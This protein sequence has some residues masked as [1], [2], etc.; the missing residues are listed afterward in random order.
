MATERDL[1]TAI[2]RR[3]AAF[4]PAASPSG[5]RQGIGDD[6]AIW[7][8]TPAT[9]SLVTTDTLVEGVHFDRRWHPPRLLGR[10]AVAV[11]MSDIAAMGGTPR[12]ALLSL[13]LGEAENPA[14]LEMMLD[15]LA[16]AVAA[17]GAVLIGGDT[18]KSPERLLLTV[19]II[20][21]S[22]A[23]RACLRSGGQAG[24]SIWVGGPLGLA[25]GGLELCR[26]DLAA[27]PQWQEAVQAHLDPPAQVELG[28]RLAAAGVVH[29]MMDL[30][31]GLA[32][33]LAHIC[34]ASGVGAE[35]EAE[36][37][38]VPDLLHRAAAVCQADPL[39]WALCGGE[40]YRL[41][42]T[43]DP[44]RDGAIA[45]LGRDLA[46]TTLTRIGRLTA[47]PPG[48]PGVLLRTADGQSR[49]IG[50]GGYDHFRTAP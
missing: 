11:N 50:Y 37:L 47:P 8:P 30:S 48:G 23:S 17:Y 43:A 2:A 3:A 49:E 31:D 4:A 14:W 5:L 19:T 33:D 29:A 21:E 32:T 15:G 16:E 18:V 24:D 28:R 41:L 13:G 12:Y 25:A 6:C 22:P 9:D 45:E 26:R 46:D 10:K 20:G 1:I 36:L 34:A 40:D 35:V 7:Q 42:F 27:D 39:N 44:A 38:P